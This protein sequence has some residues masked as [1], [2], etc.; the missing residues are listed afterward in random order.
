MPPVCS[1]R[2]QTPPASPS[3]HQA[4]PVCRALPG[5]WSVRG[6]NSRTARSGSRETSYQ[7]VGDSGFMLGNIGKMMEK[8][9][10]T[11][12]NHLFSPTVLEKKRMLRKK[13]HFLVIFP[14]NSG[15]GK[16]GPRKGWSF[17]LRRMGTCRAHQHNFAVPIDL[18]D[19]PWEKCCASGQQFFRESSMISYDNGKSGNHP[20]SVKTIVPSGNLT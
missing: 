13:T 2:V 17:S 11:S 20:W 7:P 1:S 18:H 19:H 4:T 6:P 15:R 3:C 14:C 8:W 5:C 9:W 10:E 16:N 12:G